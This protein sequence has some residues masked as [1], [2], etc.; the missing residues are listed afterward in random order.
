VYLYRSEE[1]DKPIAIPWAYGIGLGLCV[2]AI[3]VIGSLSAPWLDWALQ[4]AQSLF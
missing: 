2:L 1:E 4:A 3:V